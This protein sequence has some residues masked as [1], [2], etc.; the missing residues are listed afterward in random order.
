LIGVKFGGAPYGT[1]RESGLSEVDHYVA[2]LRR[3]REAP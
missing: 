1:L 2:G 3:R